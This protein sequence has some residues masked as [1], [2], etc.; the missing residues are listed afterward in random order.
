MPLASL[1]CLLAALPLLGTV[2]HGEAWWVPAA[3]LTAAVAGISALYRLSGWNS[4]PVPF[5]QLFAVAFLSTPLFAPQSALL[6]LLPS[7]DSPD[8]L[9]RAL[10]E[11]I[12]TID[13]NAPPVAASAGVTMI[14]ALVFAVFA[15]ASD[16]LAVTARCPGMVGGLL[17]ALV[18]VH[19]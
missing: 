12:A 10:E 13:G 11:G 7:A 2:V 15:M 16:F 4:L 8:H 9:V 17:L 14:I 6:G 19:R 18:R 1:V 3:V 5:L